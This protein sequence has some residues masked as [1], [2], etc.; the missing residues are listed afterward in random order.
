MNMMMSTSRKVPHD[1]LSVS[2][3]GGFMI[4]VECGISYMNS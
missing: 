3:L 1:E 2:L 4:M